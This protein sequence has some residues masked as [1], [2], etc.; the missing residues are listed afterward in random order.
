[1]RGEGGKK[2]P[3]ARRGGG[4]EVNSGLLW[5]GGGE[6]GAT[7]AETSPANLTGS[8]EDYDHDHDDDSR[9]QKG[10]LLGC[11]SVTKVRPPR[12]GFKTLVTWPHG[13]LD[14]LI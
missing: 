7:D 12:K 9:V 1:M 14:R 13:C 6:V 5:E 10:N 4:S 2:E 8:S 11:P 3:Q